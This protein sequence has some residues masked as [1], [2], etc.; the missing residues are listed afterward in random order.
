MNFG[1]SASY[2]ALWALAI[3]QGLVALA[4]LKQ[5]AELRAI[6]G[7]GRLPSEDP[8]PVGSPA[9]EFEGLDSRHGRKISSRDTNERGV[10]VLFLSACP[11]CVRLADDLRQPLA[12]DLPPIVAFCLGGEG[13][14]SA[15]MEKLTPQVHLLLKNAEEIAARYRVSNTPTAVIVDPHGTIRG[16]GH[17]ASMEDLRQLVA[18]SLGRISAQTDTESKLYPAVAS[19]V[20]LD[21]T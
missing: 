19:T 3:F 13:S 8:L 4:L 11:V 18:K 20:Q 1:F 16:Y 17:P 5:L 10:V 21:E 2:I 7:H 15:I 14:C 9:P 6:A 12:P